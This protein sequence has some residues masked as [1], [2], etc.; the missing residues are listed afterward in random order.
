MTP[1]STPKLSTGTIEYDVASDSDEDIALIRCDDVQLNVEVEANV[2]VEATAANTTFTTI[3]TENGGKSFR[4]PICMETCTKK[5]NLVRQST[6]NIKEMQK[7]LNSWRL[8]RHFVW[9]VEN[10]SDESLT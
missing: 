4:C 9:I 10:I 7:Y 3:T 1:R 8:A 6:G 5:A 2:T